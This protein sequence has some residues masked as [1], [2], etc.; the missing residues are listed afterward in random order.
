MSLKQQFEQETGL[1]A[2]IQVIGIA[3]ASDEYV[4]WLEAKLSDLK[5]E[6]EKA[7]EA[8]YHA[9]GNEGANYVASFYGKYPTV[10]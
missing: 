5:A 10:Y 3:Y 8:G 9:G 6:N 2:D 7:Y 1:T 4:D